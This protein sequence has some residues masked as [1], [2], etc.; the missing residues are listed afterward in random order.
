MLADPKLH[1][2]LVL[3]YHRVRRALGLLGFL[4]PFFLIFGGML[5]QTAP[6]PSLSD[7][8]HTVQRD[9]FVGVLFA[10]GIF[11]FSYRGYPKSAD[12]L[13]SDDWITTIAGLG[14]FGVALFPN[15]NPAQ[16][17]S[18]PWHV[19]FGLYPTAVLH[20]VSAFVFLLS[21][22]YICLVKFTRGANLV[23]R[24]IYL[25]CGWTVIAMTVATF[26]ASWF[27]VMGPAL[28]QRLVVEYNLVLWVESVAVWAFSVSWMVKGKAE[29][30]IRLRNLAALKK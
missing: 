27:K 21:L 29:R 15:E 19:V 7:Y 17:I 28:P 14:A 18:S 16:L 10:I 22:A 6:Q 9:I 20:Y 26:V 12:E 25:A 8:Y 5:A 3:S 13:L 11:L 2:E 30:L 4:L 24:R 23:R 1:N